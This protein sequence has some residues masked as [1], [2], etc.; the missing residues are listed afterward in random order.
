MSSSQKRMESAA[1]PARRRMAK[2]TT[3]SV[4][5]GRIANHTLWG[6]DSWIASH[7]SS[8]AG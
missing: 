7:L 8:A 1:W 6:T 4:Q 3:V 2:S 5:S